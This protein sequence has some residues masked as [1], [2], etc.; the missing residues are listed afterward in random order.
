MIWNV[1]KSIYQGDIEVTMRICLKP[2]VLLGF[3]LLCTGCV[4]NTFERTTKISEEGKIY[5][6]NIQAF[7]DKFR[8]ER[9]RQSDVALKTYR[10][11]EDNK[12][13]LINFIKNEVK[14]ADSDLEQIHY[15]KSTGKILESLF[16]DLGTLSNASI[17]EKNNKAVAELSTSIEDY[18]KAIKSGNK[19]T[20]E[21]KKQFADILIQGFDFS[22]ANK[23]NQHVKVLEKPVRE[24]IALNI[25][26]IKS[27]R[28]D[29]KV[30]E[31]N[32]YTDKYGDMVGIYA[33][34]AG[35]FNDEFTK[36]MGK[37][38]IE[39]QFSSIE[40]QSYKVLDLW[41]AYVNNQVDDVTLTNNARDVNNLLKNI[42]LDA[43][44]NVD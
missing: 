24:L 18:N 1:R 25:F 39:D 15:M 14:W 40:Q 42:K 9:I 34:K 43:S 16:E 31:Q 11:V 21:G 5:T 6:T 28:E 33:N 17:S 26:L 35:G 38:D 27:F 7:S 36:V 4:T 3:M 29:T 20:D 2:I 23:I 22:R 44:K 8:E 37:S 30:R 10:S 13:E 32:E 12:V 19:F 41:N